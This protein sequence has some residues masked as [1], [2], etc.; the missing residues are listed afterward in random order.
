MDARSFHLRASPRYLTHN[1]PPT[2]FAR[3]PPGAS[4]LYFNASTAHS[5]IRAMTLVVIDGLRSRLMYIA[6][7]ESHVEGVGAPPDSNARSI[8]FAAANLAAAR[9][10]ARA[11][12]GDATGGPVSLADAS[13]LP[14]VSMLADSVASAPPDGAELLRRRAFQRAGHGQVRLAKRVDL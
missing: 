12:R 5:S 3:H 8:G 11:A 2:T 1:R 7:S 9:T 14:R 13:L 10:S 4:C 6:A